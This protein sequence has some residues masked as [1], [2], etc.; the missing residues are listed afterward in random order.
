MACKRSGVR[1]PLAP[2]NSHISH[3]WTGQTRSRTRSVRAAEHVPCPAR[4]ASQYPLLAALSAEL[5]SAAHGSAADLALA[6]FTVKPPVALAAGT[7]A[8]RAHLAGVGPAPCHD[9]LRVRS[10]I[11]T[12]GG[13]CVPGAAGKHGRGNRRGQ[14]KF[15]TMRFHNSRSFDRRDGHECR[16][17][18]LPRQS[19][20]G[21]FQFIVCQEPTVFPL[22]PARCRNGTRHRATQVLSK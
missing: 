13:M 8:C 12:I 10:T 3:G 19:G 22:F 7:L 18:Q 11:L 20:D 15:E 16:H 9:P 17:F 21:L 6:R 14:S 5:D 4:H 2:P 1:L